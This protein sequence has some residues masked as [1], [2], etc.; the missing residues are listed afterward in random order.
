MDIES[1]S[2]VFVQAIRKRGK[3]LWAIHYDLKQIWALLPQLDY[4]I[5]HIFRETNT[6]ADFLANM[7]LRARKD[8]VLEKWDDFPKQLRGLAKVDRCGIFNLRCKFF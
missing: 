4:S 8:I 5:D 1:N 3:A 2:M 7:G 6:V